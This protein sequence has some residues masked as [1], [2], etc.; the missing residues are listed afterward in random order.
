MPFIQINILKGRSPEKKERLIREVSDLVSEV[1]EAP[2]K[3]ACHD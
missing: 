1:L 2:S 3:C